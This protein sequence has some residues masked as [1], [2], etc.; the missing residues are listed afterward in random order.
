MQADKAKLSLGEVLYF[1]FFIILSV[2]KGLGID[3]GRK[4]FALLVIAAL[5]F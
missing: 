2:A 5:F 1:A 3:E 4:V